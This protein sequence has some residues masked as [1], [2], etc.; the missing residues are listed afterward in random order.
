MKAIIEY[1]YRGDVSISQDELPALLRVAELLKVK[2][3]MEERRE[4]KDL[5]RPKTSS[6]APTPPSSTP[7]TSPRA[8]RLSH[9]PTSHPIHTPTS[10]PQGHMG[11]N[12]RPFLTPP[13]QG[14]TPPFPMW[15]LPGLFPTPHNMF[16]QRED[17]KPLSPG[18]DLFIYSESQIYEYIA[19]VFY[20]VVFSTYLGS[21]AAEKRV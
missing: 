13:G 15:P 18:T 14:S 12:F 5:S 19:R 6:P 1:M 7:T 2:G 11:H 20:N 3:M 8:E 21:N 4:C 9:P 10:I 17:M 16:S